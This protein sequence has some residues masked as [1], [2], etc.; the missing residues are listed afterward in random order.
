[1]QRRCFS[2]RRR[3]YPTAGFVL[4]YHIMSSL[5]RRLSK[6]ELH[7]P[8]QGPVQM[9]DANLL[10]PEVFA[11]WQTV[12]INEMTLDQLGLLEDNLRRLPV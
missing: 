8:A 6:L 5:S 2:L 7:R 12:G 1:M 3:V 11:L 4:Y 9:V 10:D